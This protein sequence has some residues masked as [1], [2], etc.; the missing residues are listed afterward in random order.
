MG[1]GKTLE[2]IVSIAGQLDPSLQKSLAGATKKFSGMK[3]GMAA[4][5]TAA[6]AATG[7]I[8]KF[9]ADSVKSAAAFETQM[10]NVS[11]LLD[12]T[13]EQVKK[14]TSELGNGLI[15]VSNQTGVATEDLTD[16][17]Y[18]MISAVGDSPDVL[19][20]VKIAAEGAAAGGATTTD[21]I[22]LLSAVTKA[23]GD[24]SSDAMGKVSDLAFTAV[25]L[26]QTTFPELANSIK[27]VTGTSNTLG[28]SQEELFGIMATTTGV[29]GDT[30]T[31]ATQLKAIYSNLMKPTDAMSKALDSMGFSSGQ[32]A[33]QQLGLQG[34]L[35]ALSDSCNGDASAMAQMFSSS[36]ALNMVIPLTTSLSDALTEKTKAM[37]EATGATSEAFGRQTDTLQYNIQMIKNLGKNFMTSI[38]QKILP[39][40]REAAQKIFPAL[41]NGLDAI[42]PVLDNV[43]VALSPLISGFGD[44][45]SGIFPNIEGGLSGMSNLWQGLK[46]PIQAIAENIIPVFKDVFQGIGNMFTQLQPVFAE[47]ASNLFPQIGKIIQALTPIL[48]TIGSALSPVFGMITQLVSSLLP[49]LTNVINFLMP[50][51]QAVASVIASVLGNAFNIVLPIIQN[52]INV[53][54]SLCDF[55][56]NVFTL[57]WS[58]A[59]ENVKSIFSNCWQAIVGLAKAQINAVIGVINGVISGINA[60]GFTIPDW[61][62]VVGGKAFKINVPQIPMFAAGG[63]TDGPSIAGE[64]GTEAVISFDK[65]HR[66]ENLSYWAKAGQMLGV[67]NGSLGLGGGSNIN[68]TFAPNV[69]IN[70]SGY[71]EGDILSAIRREE[72]NF[73][74]MLQD[75]LDRRGGQ[76]YGTSYS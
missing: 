17:L 66:D 74:D 20:K 59:W 54:S 19:D 24:T 49:A 40:V 47:F 13:T 62:P 6:V 33:I 72:E 4:L 30:A 34:T 42:G 63:F 48:Q 29:T 43:Y 12:G 41:Q 64:A 18:Q 1:R 11:T 27:Q 38:G 50:I 36:E 61:V 26:G 60:C 68:V 55:I 71:N 21:A 32:A 70:G 25:K 14:R 3:I 23:Y 52:V 44:L 15:D 69:T 31:A 76:G 2:A 7:A 57:N 51:I 73:M 28:V 58:A 35:Q 56:T 5:G 37:Y 9:G 75:M 67:N 46:E 16:G 10:A 39:V 22:N 45:V 65:A 53:I 8:V